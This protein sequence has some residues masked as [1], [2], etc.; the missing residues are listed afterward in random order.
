MS[1]PVALADYGRPE[2]L[3]NLYR[4]G[5]FM[6]SQRQTITTGL[7]FLFVENMNVKS[8]S[9]KI[10]MQT[11]RSGGYRSTAFGTVFAM[12]VFDISKLMRYHRSSTIYDWSPILT[13]PTFVLHCFLHSYYS[14][15][16]CV[17]ISRAYV[18]YS[19]GHRYCKDQ[20]KDE[21]IVR[22]YDDS[23]LNAIL[24]ENRITIRSSVTHTPTKVWERWS[25]EQLWGEN[26]DEAATSKL[27]CL[28]YHTFYRWQGT[29]PRRGIEKKM[30]AFVKI[31]TGR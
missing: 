6:V 12:T 5:W 20:E 2:E 19:F 23:E 22:L 16:P 31:W 1:L 13:V 29:E 10:C 25:G 27:Y 15:S 18:P 3:R 30:H 14:R 4:E 24:T 26:L 7:S 17:L 28:I 11:K 8:P 21:G 9:D